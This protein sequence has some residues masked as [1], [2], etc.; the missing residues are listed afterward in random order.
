[1]FCAMYVENVRVH[2]LSISAENL[3]A[4]FGGIWGHNYMKSKIFQDLINVCKICIILKIY[5]IPLKK[6][7][8]HFFKPKQTF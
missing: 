6:V 1:M 5:I 3:S 8:L 4:L 2:N 7:C